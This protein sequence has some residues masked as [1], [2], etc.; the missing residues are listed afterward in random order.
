[1]R[2]GRRKKSGMLKR[3]NGAKKTFYGSIG[4]GSD[5]TPNTTS[6]I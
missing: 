1:M 2:A 3:N 4:K 6:E 5:G